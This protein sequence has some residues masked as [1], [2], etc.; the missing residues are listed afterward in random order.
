MPLNAAD[1]H[2]S[3]ARFVRR[4][5]A[6]VNLCDV[7]FSFDQSLFL[8]GKTIFFITNLKT[9]KP[10]V[11]FNSNA[12][13]EEIDLVAQAGTIIQKSISIGDKIAAARNK[14]ATKAIQAIR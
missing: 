2:T 8:Y 12:V 1:S 6:I 5:L 3:A 13:R 9:K 7:R 11:K 14:M 4:V 10:I